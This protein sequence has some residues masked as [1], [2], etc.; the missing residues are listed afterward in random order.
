MSGLSLAHYCARTGLKT[1]VIEKSERV[2]SPIFENL[3]TKERGRNN[4]RNY[5]SQLQA[6][7]AR[8]QIPKASK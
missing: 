2:G 6:T 4:F 5:A 3:A 1:L 8:S 7:F